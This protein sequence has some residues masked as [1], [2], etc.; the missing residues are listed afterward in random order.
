MNP[1]CV[2]KD[3]SSCSLFTHKIRLAEELTGELHVLI[4]LSLCINQINHEVDC[5]FSVHSVKGTNLVFDL[6]SLVFKTSCGDT[7]CPRTFGRVWV[8]FEVSCM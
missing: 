4:R 5:T 8:H 3:T 2:H 1:K 6:D 7:E